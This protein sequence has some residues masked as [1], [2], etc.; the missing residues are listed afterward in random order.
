[1]P[2]RFYQPISGDLKLWADPDTFVEADLQKELDELLEIQELS[3]GAR[4]LTQCTNLNREDFDLFIQERIDALKDQLD[5]FNYS[6]IPLVLNVKDGAWFT[7]IA[8]ESVCGEDVDHEAPLTIDGQTNT[9]WQHDIDEEHEIIWKLRDYRKRIAKLQIRI[10]SSSRNLLTD[11]DIY[12][13]DSLL[14]IDN[15]NNKIF[16]DI[17]FTV[18]NTWEELVLISKKNIKYIKFVGFGSQHVT[19]EIRIQEVQAWV[20]TVEYN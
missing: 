11:L 6:N 1:M 20:T 8:V 7:P 2:T 4:E 15:I 17:N 13:S 18:N 12:A 5:F 9:Y 10:G 16:T 3:E 14:E 19:N